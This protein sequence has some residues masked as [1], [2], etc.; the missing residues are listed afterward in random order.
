M[1]P[2][3]R[4]AKLLHEAL[5]DA[6]P[7]WE[8]LAS[9]VRL[10][11]DL[12]LDRVASPRTNL[13]TVV[14]DLVAWARSEAKIEALVAGARAANPDNTRL[15]ALDPAELSSALGPPRRASIEEEIDPSSAVYVPCSQVSDDGWLAS[16][17]FLW[18]RLYRILPEGLEASP[19][20]LE[21]RLL[22]E[23]PGFLRRADPTPVMPRAL[24]SYTALLEEM[25]RASP[26]A[27][28]RIDALIATH[29]GAV[30]I[31]RA[32][33]DDSLI[34]LWSEHGLLSGRAGEKH[35]VQ[36]FW[37]DLWLTVL[38]RELGLQDGV[39]PVTDEPLT[40]ELIRLCLTAAVDGS[41]GRGALARALEPHV[42]GGVLR[43]SL[44][45]PGVAPRISR[46]IDVEAWLSAKRQLRRARQDYHQRVTRWLECLPM[47]LEER[48]GTEAVIAEI[49]AEYRREVAPSWLEI[50]RVL[51]GRVSDWLLLP[52]A[53]TAAPRGAHRGIALFEYR[54]CRLLR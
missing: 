24:E 9:M 53:D 22:D 5:L 51:G 42:A 21:E 39:M 50:A 14:L 17:F 33:V 46:E 47:Q 12:S 20:R 10:E 4:D 52:H 36:R 43:A 35:R 48:T 27:R 13:R 28:A 6:F 30:T 8:A 32:K 15:R 7:S 25:K 34:E 31:H 2:A 45:A 41:H 26:Q 38:G 40:G 11:L 29:R 3:G 37:A 18:D 19:G 16:S 54:V 23:A 44:P 1:K 49:H